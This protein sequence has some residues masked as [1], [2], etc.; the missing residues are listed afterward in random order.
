MAFV[1]NNPGIRILRMSLECPERRHVVLGE[2]TV[3]VSFEL[4]DRLARTSFG[5]ATHR[6]ID[7]TPFSY[8]HLGH[9]VVFA[10]RDRFGGDLV[11]P[12][13]PTGRIHAALQ[14]L[15]LGA[16]A[17]G[18]ARRW[19]CENGF[20]FSTITGSPTPSRDRVRLVEA[21]RGRGGRHPS[22]VWLGPA[23]FVLSPDDETSEWGGWNPG[24]DL[25]QERGCS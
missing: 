6:S 16:C 20:P 21:D 17:L 19:L 3:V 15:P 8:S 24:F 23:F 1:V 5:R 18:C 11:A 10:P 14:T 2:P 12:H 9:G 4:I 7:L 22:L 25:N 13:L